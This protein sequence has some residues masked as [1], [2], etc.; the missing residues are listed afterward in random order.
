MIDTESGIIPETVCDRKR[1]RK[2]KKK[3]ISPLFF[4]IITQHTVHTDGLPAL[5][6]FSTY[7]KKTYTDTT[8]IKCERFSKT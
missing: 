6:F 4:M 2:R 7:H 5:F 8:V 3:Q 1:S